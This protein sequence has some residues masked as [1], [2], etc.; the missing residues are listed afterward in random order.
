MKNRLFVS[1]AVKH[2]A[3]GIRNSSEKDPKNAVPCKNVNGLFKTKNDEPAHKDIKNH[4]K[5]FIFVVVNGGKNSAQRRKGPFRKKNEPRGFGINRSHC[6]KKNGRISS[7]NKKI[8]GAVVDDLHHLFCKTGFEPVINA[9]NGVNRNHRKTV[10]NASHNV[11]G[12]AVHCRNDDAK[13]KNN[14]SKSAAHNVGGHVGNFFSAG[15]IGKD[16]FSKGSSSHNFLSPQKKRA[17]EPGPTWQ[18][19]TGSK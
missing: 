15:V 11:P 10:D 19:Q 18:P 3:D 6:R 12:V 14:N 4:R 7:G 16:P 8:N 17:R 2:R 9:R 1:H 5:L 13:K